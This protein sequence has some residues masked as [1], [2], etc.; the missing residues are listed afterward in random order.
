MINEKE[1][2]ENIKQQDKKLAKDFKASLKMRTL[3]SVIK[4]SKINTEISL[5]DLESLN[6]FYPLFSFRLKKQIS[7]N[8]DLPFDIDKTDLSDD[9][10]IL[11]DNWPTS[12]HHFKHGIMRISSAYH[13]L[14]LSYSTFYMGAPNSR[15]ILIIFYCFK[16]KD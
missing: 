10:F 8:T 3:R 11:G 13:N 1:I 12:A 7:K 5:Q 16:G 2:Y 15:T 14:R 9:I 4:E 6:N